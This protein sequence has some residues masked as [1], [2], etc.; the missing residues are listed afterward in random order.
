MARNYSPE[1]LA[2]QYAS[3]GN[4]QRK[5]AKKA[6]KKK[7]DPVMIREDTSYSSSPGTFRE[8]V[9]DDSP[10]LYG[11]WAERDVKNHIGF[12]LQEIDL[13][14]EEVDTITTKAMDLIYGSLGAP[15]MSTNIDAWKR[16][17]MFAVDRSIHDCINNT[18]TSMVVGLADLFRQVIETQRVKKMNNANNGNGIPSFTIDATVGV[19]DAAI[20]SETV[21]DGAAVAKAEVVRQVMDASV[22]GGVPLSH[23]DAVGIVDKV[24]AMAH[25][26]KAGGM[27]ADQFIDALQ[28]AEEPKAQPTP[29]PTQQQPPMQ[30]EST[31]KKVAYYAAG[32]VVVGAVGYGIYRYMKN[33]STAV[34]DTAGN[35]VSAMVGLAEVAGGVASAASSATSATMSMIG[36]LM[37]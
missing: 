23:D 17:A 11:E 36:D 9:R 16:S 3:K 24:E 33:D 20:K 29:S 32:A 10:K 18:T 37:S 4:F 28:E 30:S 34:A 25:L 35:V 21:T 15:F 1:D 12:N 27:T 13:T 19:E 8:R 7:E 5:Y 26:A 2:D 22:A 6:G 14:K 31:L